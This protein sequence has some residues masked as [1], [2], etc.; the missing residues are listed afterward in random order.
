MPRRV[1]NRKPATTSHATDA[2]NIAKP[3]AMLK[4]S[5][6]RLSVTAT[7]ATIWPCA[8]GSNTQAVFSKATR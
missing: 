2:R 7:M 4:L 5:R 1:G 3:L 6:T 8:E